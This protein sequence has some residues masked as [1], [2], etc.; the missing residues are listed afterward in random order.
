M[1]L[2]LVPKSISDAWVLVYSLVPRKSETKQALSWTEDRCG[3][4]CGW[5]REGR[6]TVVWTGLG[7][8]GRGARR[9]LH[10]C[11]R[12]CGWKEKG[13]RWCG[14]GWGRKGGERDGSCRRMGVDGAVD[15]RKGVRDGRCMGVDGAVN[16]RERA[17]GRGWGRKGGERD[18]SCRRM[19]VDGAVDGRK[20]ARDGRRMGVD[21]AGGRKRREVHGCGR[22]YREG[23][24]KG[25]RDEAKKGRE[26]SET[27]GAW[28]W[29]GLGREEGGARDGGAWV[30]R[31]VAKEGRERDGRCV[32]VDGANEAW[33]GPMLLH[34]SRQNAVVRVERSCATDMAAPGQFTSRTKPGWG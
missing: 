18:G 29:T 17:R 8:E 22:G 19:G 23:R 4:G 16:G 32:G 11:G 12:G 33:R 31:V 25:A 2:L 10:G 28:V 1:P 24:R 27:G 34:A 6:E 9:K 30:W 13:A 5:N 20:G 14:R 26:G 7:K 15:G 3:R 21:E